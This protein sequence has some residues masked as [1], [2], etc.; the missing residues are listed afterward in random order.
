MRA[1]A[2]TL[3]ALALAGCGGSTRRAAPPAPPHI[4]RALAR[5]LAAQASA[6]AQSLAAGDGCGAQVQANQLRGEVVLL[7][8]EH[9]IP[10]RYRGTLTAAVEDLPDRITCNPAPPP[11]P[12]P[13]PPP[14][15]DHGHGH[16]DHGH[17]HGPGDH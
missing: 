13:S 5:S 8:S 10:M 4:P 16:H 6:V 3:V 15:H 17:G 12:A 9:R 14:P 7:V 11:A 1:A 2:I